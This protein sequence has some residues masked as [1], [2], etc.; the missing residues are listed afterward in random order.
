MGRTVMDQPDTFIWSPPLT[1]LGPECTPETLEL[2]HPSFR[3]EVAEYGPW[4]PGCLRCEGEGSRVW[5]AGH[6]RKGRPVY[7][8]GTL[9]SSLDAGWHLLAKGCLHPWGSVLAAVQTRGRGQLRREWHS[10]PGNIFGALLLPGPFPWP[11]ELLPLL[12][13]Y[14]ILVAL[15][16]KGLDLQIKWPND[17][18]LGE[19]KVG[20]ILIEERQGAC[21][22]G[23][24]INLFSPPFPPT[25]EGAIVTAGGLDQAGHVFTPIALWRDLVHV[26][27]NCYESMLS[28]HT[29]SEFIPLVQRRLAFL[30]RR[31][32]LAA[33]PE[34]QG[35]IVGISDNGGLLLQDGGRDT[36]VTSG[37]INPVDA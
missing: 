19:K 37:S 8:A 26:A 2:L 14:L 5:I 30:G 29:S 24:G 7:V 20:G 16:E 3:D 34:V 27:E 12:V 15:R 28:S 22:A 13:G 31:V 18:L 21:L 4:R 11:P 17:L 32:A 36:V 10:P 1:D 6:G 33:H 35:R 9:S 23:I 25:R